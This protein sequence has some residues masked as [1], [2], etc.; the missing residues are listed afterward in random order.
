MTSSLAT[1]L[2]IVFL[3]SKGMTL[4]TVMLGMIHFFLAEMAMTL[5]MVARVK[6]G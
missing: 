6:I 5:S 4:F 2:E 1:R 3:V